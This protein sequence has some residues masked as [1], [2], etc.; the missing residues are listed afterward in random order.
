MRPNTYKYIRIG[1]FTGHENALTEKKNVIVES[2]NS[3]EYE[4]F[5]Y[6]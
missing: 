5:E 4:S 3:S 6:F 2:I 1:V